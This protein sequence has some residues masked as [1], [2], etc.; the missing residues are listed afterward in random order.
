MA[1]DIGSEHLAGIAYADLVPVLNDAETV[2]RVVRRG[3]APP[4]DRREADFAVLHLRTP[5]IVHPEV[6]AVPGFAGREAELATL[7]ET[8]W[9]QAGTAAPTDAPANVPVAA[10]A[11][12][13]LGGVGKSVLARE[14]AW[15]NRARYRG[16]WWV[17]AER[18]ETLA[19]DLIDLGAR[20]IPGLR[21][22]PERDRAARRALDWIE[23]A[24]FEKP[25]LIVY[26][27]V[28]EPGRIDGLTPRTGAHVLVTT[29]W[30]DWGRAAPVTVGVFPPEVA[31]DFL[32]ESTGGTDRASAERSAAA[33]GYLPLALDQA[34]AYVRR[35]GIDFATYE[36]L[37]AEVLRK[38][39]RGVDE[40]TP[41]FATFTL[42]IDKAS[43]SCPEAQKVMGLCA[44]LAPDRIPLSL[45]VDDVLTETARADAVAAL[46]EVSLAALDSLD[47]GSPAISMHRLVQATMRARL[48]EMGEHENAAALAT[49]LVSDAYPNPAGDVRN[50]SACARLMPHAMAV[51]E[52]APDSGNGADKTA[53][54]LSQTALNCVSKAAYVEAEPLLRRALAIGEARCGPDHPSVAMSLNDLA[55]L[56]LD[57]GRPAEAEPLMRRALAIGEANYRPDRPGVATVLNDLG[58]LLQATNRLA[59]AEPLY[60]RALAI[61]EAS[62]GPHHPN[63][64]TSLYNL[65][66]L[67]R[68]TNRLA[69]AEPLMRRHVEILEKFEQETGHRHPHYDESRESLAALL[70]EAAICDADV[71]VSVRPDA[72]E[73][74]AASAE[75]QQR[76]RGFMGGLFPR[77]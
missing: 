32:L 65:A 54:L 52:H 39:P 55:G 44:F 37:A 67:L 47:D 8:L 23:L 25:W 1:D 50:W 62:Y 35:T 31:A 6:K 18:R 48:R 12:K 51:F 42:A 20:F 9:R 74:L 22:V 33:L 61:Y 24:G 43:Q 10:A 75:S 40:D 28:E 14:Y 11:V 46:Q 5:Q 57:T 26:D 70:V 76:K 69:E 19:D 71:P 27:N 73:P 56:L 4:P 66:Q 2:A 64:A 77:M 38:T 72:T 7:E 34:A 60:R 29:R 49:E 59:E 21:E 68:E 53:L 36:A 41:V 17:R 63:V 16:I 13:G 45:F 15:R 30:S 3:V 58:R